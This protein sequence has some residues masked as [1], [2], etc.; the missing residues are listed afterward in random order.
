MKK[1]VFAILVVFTLIVAG[2]PDAAGS[3][4]GGGISLTGITVS[5][6]PG[7]LVYY[8]G[9][10]LDIRGLAVRA[11]YS[12]GSEEDVPFEELQLSGFESSSAGNKTITVEY[13]GKSASF[14]VTVSEITL[15]GIVIT[16]PPDKTSY[17]AGESL[18]LGGLVVT[19]TYSNGSTANVEHEFL[20]VSGFNSASPGNYTVVI[21]YGER[22]ADFRISVN[23]VTLEG[24]TITANPVKTNYYRGEELDITGLVVIASYSNNST[25]IIGH[26][27]L[28][29]TGFDSGAPGNKTVTVNFGGK[30]AGF[31]VE[32]ED[33]A[34]T[35]INITS[36]PVKTSYNRGDEF[37]PAGL[38][39]QASYSDGTAVILHVGSLLFLGFDTIT[40]GNKTVTVLY[41][42][43]SDS[44]TINVD[45]HLLT[46]IAITSPPSKTDYHRNEPLDLG[47]LVVTATYSDGTSAAIGHSALRISGFDSSSPGNKTV[48]VAYGGKTATF[49]VS[50]DGVTLTGIMIM[51]T[52]HKMEYYIGEAINLVGLVVTARYSNGSSG[53]IDHN[54]LVITGFDSFTSGLK[55]ITVSYGDMSDVF[56]VVV[57]AVNL[58]GLEVKTGPDNLVYTSGEELDLG[59]LVVT[60]KY[61]N[62]TTREVEFD[63][64]EQNNITTEPQHG[65]TLMHAEH[66]NTPVTASCGTFHAQ[67]DE[68]EVGKADP[69]ITEW[70]AAAAITYGQS[71]SESTLTGGSGSV[72][73]T[74]AWTDGTIVPAITN[75]GYEVT[76]TPDDAANYSAVTNT[77]AVTVNT[78]DPTITWPVATPITYGQLLS[79]S[80]LT[81]G[82]SDVDGTF[83]WTDGT[84]VPTVANSGYEVTFTPND[85]VNYNTRTN[86]VAVTVYKR[87][88]S[89]VTITVHGT[90][91]YTGSE[92]TPT[93]TVTDSVI[94]S[95]SDYRILNYSNNIN[96]GTATVAII[97]VA[98]TGSNYTG[99]QSGT[100][101][102]DKADPTV[103]AWPF[104]S[105]IT[106]GEAL[107]GSALNDDA[108]SVPGSFAW[109]DG[110]IVPTVT[111]SG[112]SVTFTPD[113]PNYNTLTQII[114]IYVFK[115]KPNVND[116]PV[117][118]AITY[119]QPLSAS[120]LTGGTSDNDGHFEWSSGWIIPTVNNSGYEVMFVPDDAANYNAV[121]EDVAV[122]VNPKMITLSI[123]D[124]SRTTF[125]PLPGETSATVTVNITGLL[126]TDT[127]S[128]LCNGFTLTGTTLVYDG[129]YAF[130]NPYDNTLYF[131][132]SAGINYTTATASLTNITI[133][134]GRADGIIPI[135]QDNIKDFNSYANT[136]NGLSRH[137][138]LM[139]N[140][141]LPHPAPGGSNW[142]AIGRG[143]GIFTGSFDG[144][145]HTISNLTINSTESYQGMF[146]YIRNGRVEN[147]GIVGGSVNGN[148]W[149][150]GVAGVISFSTT[151]QNCYYTGSVTGETRVGG[152]VGNIGT[153]TVQ[154]CYSTGSINGNYYVGGVVG[155]NDLGTVQ[156][157]YS[158]S[159]VTGDERVGGVVGWNGYNNSGGKV[160]NCYSTG[161][162]TANDY[163]GGAVGEIL[164]GTIQDCV[165]L[166]SSITATSNTTYIGRVFGYSR[167]T[168]FIYVNYARGMAVNGSGYTPNMGLSQKD[169]YTINALQWHSASW[170]TSATNWYNSAWDTSIWFIEDGRLPLL[171]YMPG[172]LEAQN[173]M[174][175]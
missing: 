48:T 63:D 122:T 103:T 175:Q 67:T 116:W 66:D 39:V 150:G 141:T 21:R 102:I 164:N 158:T 89:N 16:S 139:G 128:I 69:E 38:E 56:S 97:G 50:V 156:N 101:T 27:A 95:E 33:A 84:T 18:D 1:V 159:S 3:G 36:P 37:D 129:V 80:A 86:T 51:N 60:L 90:F 168:A 165:A 45:E 41:S 161:S 107:S 132:A 93:P 49:N 12:N 133:Y 71:L 146:G 121:T 88:L 135:T 19:A 153:G 20:E 87:D 11:S 75:S 22:R 46:G 143:A 77:V 96:A 106:Y 169:G 114:E 14:P 65:V 52:P 157:C 7:K 62:G 134:D 9:E 160:Q 109:T 83:T 44:F 28:N 24:I 145:G 47:G 70:P 10:P 55:T 61:N 26:S 25:L 162:V 166:N 170:W 174:I 68:L 152:V 117:A 155:W 81:G 4:G 127:A 138:K 15:T 148:S 34:L 78:T 154:N 23:G 104:A 171:L 5:S 115:A 98:G 30:T 110:T 111:N 120:V 126:G 124:P 59:G 40:E 92:H 173:P 123:T 17:H 151:V 118:A 82:A 6:F 43:K 112:Y 2:C 136:S 125:T 42:S 74:F 137:Y 113:D 105:P 29:F 57:I 76:F 13:K 85:T 64:F 8:R 149:V 99:T 142:T 54:A 130:P 35:G 163:V 91:T 72:P 140:V 144:Q 108:S 94:I 73:G 31:T 131:T 147:I 100:F 172:G 53:N 79:E 58:S 167:G 119:G 32:V